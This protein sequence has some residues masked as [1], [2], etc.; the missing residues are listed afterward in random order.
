MV[1]LISRYAQSTLVANSVRQSKDNMEDTSSNHYVVFKFSI[2][3]EVTRK[4]YEIRI[5]H[6]L[7]FIEFS[8]EDSSRD[9]APSLTLVANS[10]IAD[11]VLFMCLF[12]IAHYRK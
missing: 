6:F 9:F 3:P 2:R 4:C 11:K 1:G 5:T 8:F 12:L 10:V 7:E